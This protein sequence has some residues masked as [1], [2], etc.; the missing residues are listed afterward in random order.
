MKKILTITAF[1]G[2]IGQ[3]QAT[4]S[5]RPVYR[6]NNPQIAYN[7]GYNMGYHKGKQDAQNKIAKATGA[8]ILFA[9]AGTI[10]YHVGKESRFTTTENGI[11]YRF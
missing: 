3:A 6:Y 10:I 11:T 7:N 4:H 8:V 5:M 2:I 1:L 9:I